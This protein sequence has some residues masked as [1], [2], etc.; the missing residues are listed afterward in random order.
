LDILQSTIAAKNLRLQIAAERGSPVLATFD[1]AAARH[2]F[3]IF[4]LAVIG[5]DFR[6]IFTVNY[7]IMD[8]ILRMGPK[9]TLANK[10]ALDAVAFHPGPIDYTKGG[11]FYKAAQ[12]Y[13]VKR[14]ASEIY[15]TFP[16]MT[17]SSKPKMPW[18]VMLYNE[19]T[20]RMRDEMGPLK[21]FD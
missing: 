2:A 12:D 15:G 18:K 4:S 9:S 19:V 21:I 17:K 3:E 8:A 11:A 7:Q 14:Q 13:A 1:F 5:P 20:Q 6:D 10:K 16:D